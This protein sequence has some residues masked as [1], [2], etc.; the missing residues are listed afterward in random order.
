MSTTYGACQFC[1]TVLIDRGLTSLTASAVNSNGASFCKQTL[2]SILMPIPLKC[3]GHRLS[4]LTYMPLSIINTTGQP[5][6]SNSRLNSDAL[7]GFQ[8]AR[9]RVAGRVMDCQAYIMAKMMREQRLHSLVAASAQNYCRMH[10]TVR[11]LLDRSNPSCCKPSLR[12]LSAK[13]CS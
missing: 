13:L 12:P 9:A 6:K 7:A 2:S 3:L 8:F 5:L 1:S 11:T 4:L 10:P